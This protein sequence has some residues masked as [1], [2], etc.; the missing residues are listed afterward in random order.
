MIVKRC[1]GKHSGYIPVVPF[2]WNFGAVPT[3]GVLGIAAFSED[4]SIFGNWRLHF[5][6]TSG[7]Q[8]DRIGEVVM[9]GVGR[10]V[11]VS[12][13]DVLGMGC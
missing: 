3:L 10:E 5:D 8:K 12:I 6:V 9:S 2:T 11:F 7:F 4:F 1:F 13:S